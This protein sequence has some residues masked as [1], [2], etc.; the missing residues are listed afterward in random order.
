MCIRDSDKIESFGH[1]AKI[2]MQADRQE[3]TADGKDLIY[4]ETSILDEN[5]VLVANAA[6]RVEFKVTG[7]GKLLTVDNGDSSD[8]SLIHIW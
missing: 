2:D 1:S 6:N 7:A 5:N 3:I 8:L 4:V